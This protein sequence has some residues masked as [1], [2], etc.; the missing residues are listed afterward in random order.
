MVVTVKKITIAVAIYN[1]EKYLDACIKSI[2]CNLPDWAQVI[3]I[4]DASKDAS[5]D[6]CDK[7]VSD[8]IT[9]KHF[10]ENCGVC[11]VRNYA[12]ENAQSEYICFVD[13]DDLIPP[14][15][16]DACEEVLACGKDIL[17]FSYGE[18]TNETE[19]EFDGGVSEEANEITK[20][21]LTA[22]A[23]FVVASSSVLPRNPAYAP[24]RQTSIWAKAYKVQYL[25]DNDVR[26]PFDQKKSQDL[27]FNSYAYFYASSAVF[28][29]RKMYFYRQNPT[30]VC[31]RYNEN[32]V[33]IAHKLLDNCKR[34]ID[35]LYDDE[36]MYELFLL[37]RV[38]MQLFTCMELDFF[39]KDNPK[40]PKE[41]KMEFENFCM[42]EPFK[43]AIAEY[44]KGIYWNERL[45]L[46]RLVRK[47][48]F[49]ALDL[50]YRRPILLKMYGKFCSL[51]QGGAK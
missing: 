10:E 31:H 45:L 1:V 46:L 30:S 44:E 28:L 21:E 26:F 2:V 35:C 34:A 40:S 7:Y 48:R 38:I 3:L 14:Y 17:F 41:R 18:F 13:G 33:D 9:V 12:I 6:I 39:H 8:N 15:F 50:L 32:I 23:Q 4:D 42:Q 25:L 51:M 19:I 11:A 16:F 43:S 37:Y 36:K 20:D 49:F 5:G 27:V 22:M 29:N 47:N 24:I